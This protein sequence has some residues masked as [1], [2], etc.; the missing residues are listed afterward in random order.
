[1]QRQTFNSDHRLLGS[2]ASRFGAILAMTGL[3]LLS[4]C[5]GSGDTVTDNNLPEFGK[6]GV[7]PVLESVT[8][9]PNGIVEPGDLIKITIVA[10]EALMTPVAY[11]N[12]VEVEVTGGILNW[13]VARE[14]TESEPPGNVTFSIVFQDISGELG[15][16][17]SSTTDGSAACFGPEC[18]ADDL[19]PLEGN[20]KLDFAGVG[21][22]EGDTTWWSIA[23]TGPDG[24]RACWFDDLYAFGRDGSFANVQGDE[25]WIETW[26]GAVEDGCDSPVAPHDGSNNAV[27]EYDEE[28]GTLKLTG[29]GAYLGVSKAA[30]G[31]EL[32]DPADA[33]GSVT[34]KVVELVGNSLTVR[35]DYG[36]GWWEYRLTRISNLP[37]VGKWKLSF[38]GVGPAEG[39]TTWWSIADTGPDGPRACWFDDIYHVGGDGSFQNFQDG[40]TW[41]EIW[42]GALEDGCGVPVEPHDGSTAGAWSIDAAGAN[43]RLDGV[44][45]FLGVPKAVNG[46]E[47][48][49]PAEAPAFV[50]Y[51]VVELVGDN[52]TVRIDYGGGWWEYRLERVADTDDLK[53]NWKLDFAGV[54][55]A[56]GDTTWWS[57]ADT[58]PDGP[59]AC[60]FDDLYA[61]GR[62]GSFANVQGDETWIEIWQGAVEDGCDAPVAPHDG[63]N[64]AIFEYDE[65]GA[66]LKLTAQ[67]AHLGV[68]KAANGVELTAPEFAP[69]SVTYKVAELV[70][71]N[72]TVRVDYGGGWWEYRLSRISNHPA[73]GNWK[74]DF[75]GVGPAE[76]DTTWWSIADTGPDGPR[77]CWFDDIYHVGGDGSFQNFQDG[78]TWVEIWQG[79]LEDGCGVPVEPHDGSTAGAWS[80]DAAGANVRLDGVGSFLGVPKAVN[81]AELTAPAEA[82]AF[83]SYKL[84]E[85]VGDSVTFRIDYGGGWWE[86]HLLKE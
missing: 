57:I 22:A 78:D 53:G 31:V 19:G 8:V 18:V 42:Q 72:M 84:V 32:I 79:A 15:Q 25:T 48:T 34:Y 56:E 68:S 37:V 4:A 3:L 9:Q 39:D 50:S 52:M 16:A 47:L 17:V 59:R 60:W 28:A 13:S 75:A 80:I 81:G 44:G 33:P 43:V 30:N 6:D 61:F 76:G 35:V 49:A 73:V 24:P 74:L 12:G 83:V 29:K 14:I 23:D 46:A 38:A 58:G 1:M 45:S 41:V 7:P 5:D 86:F 54:G 77:A 69:G 20:W 65:E 67:G 85:L 70:G 27:F 2:I 66:T 40:D 26:Q 82:P 51:K 71:D 64:N 62:D 63:S 21:P 36:G 11:I 55:P 10:S